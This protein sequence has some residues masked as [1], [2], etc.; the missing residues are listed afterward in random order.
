MDSETQKCKLINQRNRFTKEED[1]AI[2][3]IISEIG[4]TDWDMISK[5][6]PG[7]NK[8]QV[9]ERWV[10]YLRLNLNKDPWTK[11]E[12]KFH[13]SK[14]KEF[15]NRWKTLSLFFKNRTEICIK[16]KY[17]QLTR[18]RLD[19]ETKKK[20][21]NK[22]KEERKKNKEPLRA[23]EN[24]SKNLSKEPESMKEEIQKF[25]KNPISIFNIGTEI[26]DIVDLIW[27]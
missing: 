24:D 10:N 11:E 6:M 2:L 5:L 27:L 8:R 23:I 12:E 13:M 4:T 1:Q 22:K 3:D 21:I 20:K 16:C 14:H 17:Q 18:Q 15:G 25:L 9:R 26:D 19:K 7:R